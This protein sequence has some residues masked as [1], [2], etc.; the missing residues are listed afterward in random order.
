LLR[1]DRN[2][3]GVKALKKIN[4]ELFRDIQAMAAPDG[5]ADSE[6]LKFGFVRNTD[7]NPTV[8]VSRG[9]NEDAFRITSSNL[10]SRLVEESETSWN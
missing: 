2:S 7:L 6:V 10:R 5:G 9:R 8:R 4:E 3:G 1:D